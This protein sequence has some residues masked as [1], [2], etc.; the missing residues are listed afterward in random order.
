MSLPLESVREQLLR[1]G[2]APR[3]V[4]RYVVELR[5]HL[6]DLVDR[7]RKAGLDAQ[8]AAE[9]ARAL[10]GTETQLAQAMIETAPKAWAVRAPWAV[11]ALFPTAAVLMVILASDACLLRLLPPDQP[12]AWPSGIPNSYT[13]IF[14]AAVVF[15][16]YLLGPA[17]AAVS[18]FLALRQ[19]LSSPWIWLGLAL[20][21]IAS[22]MFGFYMHSVPSLDGRP[23][24]AL[25]SAIPNVWVHGHASRSGTATLIAARAG[26]L[27]VIAGMA[28]RMLRA[29][30]LPDPGESDHSYT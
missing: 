18:I 11:F 16:S 19:R 21:A 10:L 30:V 28:L 6:S 2:V 15:I 7:E 8:A 12:A 26:S 27:F 22:G 23:A 5:E 29:R 13:A 17:A 25:F 14:T 9:R 24:G 1:A 3:C 4:A 20:I